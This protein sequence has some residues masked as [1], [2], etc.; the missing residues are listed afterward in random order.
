M[1]RAK[2]FRNL[3][4]FLNLSIIVFCCSSCQKQVDNTADEIIALKSSVSVLQKRT[5][6]LALALKN[7]NTNLNN[8]V[9]IDYTNLYGV[10]TTQNVV[11]G[12]G[13]FSVCTSNSTINLTSFWQDDVLYSSSTNPWTP[14]GPL[15]STNGD[16]TVGWVSG[17]ICTSD[18]C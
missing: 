16:K 14:S 18:P 15:P 12:G 1:H 9:S 6:S 4:F 11:G 2:L 8:V 5:D 3:F 13:T 10:L 17:G 7:T